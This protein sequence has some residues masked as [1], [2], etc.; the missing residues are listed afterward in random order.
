MIF[1]QYCM[2]MCNTSHLLKKKQTKTNAFFFSLR[3][4]S[5]RRAGGKERRGSRKKPRR[6]A[7][8]ELRAIKSQPG[9]LKVP[10]ECCTRDLR[11]PRNIVY[12]LKGPVWDL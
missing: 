2:Y 5:R 9:N 8:Q 6:I 11:P 7:F 3:D 12:G 1:A 10:Q 4:M